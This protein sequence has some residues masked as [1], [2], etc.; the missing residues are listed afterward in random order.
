MAYKL[1]FKPIEILKNKYDLETNYKI[2]KN[3]RSGD[4][5]S[6]ISNNS[7]F[8]KFTRK[9]IKKINFKGKFTKFTRE[10]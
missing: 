7:K 5:V 2:L 10:T 6:Y 8:T 3:N 1:K 9:K 4:H